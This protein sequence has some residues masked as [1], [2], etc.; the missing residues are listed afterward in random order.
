MILLLGACWKWSSVEVM[1]LGMIGPTV[2][3]TIAGAIFGK[4]VMRV[5]RYRDNLSE[6][7]IGVGMLLV[8]W[9]LARI[10]LHIFDRIYLRKGRIK[11]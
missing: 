9:I 2:A 7:A 10:H 3:V 4:T 11:T 8:G 6:I 5:V 1:T